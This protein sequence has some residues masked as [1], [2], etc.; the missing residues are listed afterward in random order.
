[1]FFD[2]NDP[3]QLLFFILLINVLATAIGFLIAFESLKRRRPP[4]GVV[5]YVLL[6]IPSESSDTFSYL[7]AL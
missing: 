6:S 3:L 2:L 1:M 7:L 4:F 5:G